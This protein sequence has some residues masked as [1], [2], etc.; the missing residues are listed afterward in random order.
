VSGKETL[1]LFSR[2]LL[3][4]FQATSQV[5]S[6]A[7]L[8]NTAYQHK[9]NTNYAPMDDE[10]EDILRL[11][12]EPLQEIER[13]DDEIKRLTSRRNALQFFV[14]AHR[15]LLSPIRRLPPEVLQRIFVGCLPEHPSY[16]AMHSS[17]APVLLGRICSRWRDIAYGTAELWSSI[18]VVIP[19]LKVGP[20][21]AE[22]A[23]LRLTA[24]T[25]WLGRSGSLPLRI[26]VWK[27]NRGVPE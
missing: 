27:S 25:E 2:W 18:H 26:S 7:M 20:H 11:C 15:Q 9:L 1:V 6:T 10:R 19:D 24:M 5:T 16:P 22:L 13:I 17:I 4:T 12:I 14:D 8:P 21:E 3:T 23:D